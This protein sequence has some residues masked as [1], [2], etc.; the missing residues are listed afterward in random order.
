V[1]VLAVNDDGLLNDDVNQKA[2]MCSE[3]HDLKA[4]SRWKWSHSLLGVIG[5][6]TCACTVHVGHALWIDTYIS[7]V[8]EFHKRAGHTSEP[9]K[10][11]A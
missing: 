7:S 2:F 4:V 9:V 1:W 5:A 3:K 11:R 8:V 6:Y 10:T